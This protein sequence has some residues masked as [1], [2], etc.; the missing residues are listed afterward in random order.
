[1]TSFRNQTI[2]VPF[3]F[4]SPS[5][6]ALKQVLEWADESN[7]IHLIYVV[8][9][10]PT[11]INIDPPVWIPPNLDNETRDNMLA[12]MKASFGSGL[13]ESLNHHCVVGDP[14]VEIVE[15]AKNKEADIIVMPSHGRSGLSRFFL[16]SVAERVLRLSECPVLI[17]RGDVFEKD[18][19]S[20]KK[21][22]AAS[23]S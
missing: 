17:L 12:T 9:P 7:S 23:A 14:G 5:T 18:V 20:A 6:E 16:G 22:S 4:S 1:M 2:I 15:L 3:D 8:Q 10:T 21:D 13:Y 19:A 11:M